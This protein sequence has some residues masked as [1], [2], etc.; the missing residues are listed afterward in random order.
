M[1]EVYVESAP[2]TDA[3]LHNELAILRH[4][5]AEIENAEAIA[6]EELQSTV[7]QLQAVEEELRQQHANRQGQDSD[8]IWRGKL[9]QRTMERSG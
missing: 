6:I 5:L 2:T 4:R 8:S 3:Q 9:S 1:L 7:E